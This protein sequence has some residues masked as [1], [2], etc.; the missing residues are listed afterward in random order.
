MS[1]RLRNLT[2]ASA[3]HLL[4]QGHITP[5]HHQRIV[6]AASAPTMPTMPKLPAGPFGS[7]AK[8]KKAVAPPVF[9]QQAQAPIPGVGGPPLTPPGMTSGYNEEV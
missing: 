8:K 9:P 1:S 7:L 3:K 5:A 2:L 6:S 4:S